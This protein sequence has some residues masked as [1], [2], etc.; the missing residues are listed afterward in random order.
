[1]GNVHLTFQ[2]EVMINTNILHVFTVTDGNYK[3]SECRNSKKNVSRLLL[4]EQR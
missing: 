3:Q 2:N 4:W 1:M